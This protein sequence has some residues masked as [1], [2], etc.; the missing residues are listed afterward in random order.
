M[1]DVS[2]NARNEI[3]VRDVPQRVA[4]AAQVVAS[5]DRIR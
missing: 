4:L 3:F 5:L 2:L 1:R